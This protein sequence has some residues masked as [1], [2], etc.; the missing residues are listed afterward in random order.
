M[1]DDI[2]LFLKVVEAGSILSVEKKLSIPRSTISRKIR[3][4]EIKVGKD[5]LIRNYQGIVL[6]EEGRV[7]Y[8]RFKDYEKKLSSILSVECNEELS[9]VG[10]L[11]VLLP[12]SFTDALLPYLK[13]FFNNYPGIE[14][15]IL[16]SCK[17]FNMKKEIYDLAVIDYEPSQ[18]DQKFKKLFITKKVLVC[19]TN[20][21]E[22]YP[23]IKSLED[24]AGGFWVGK[25]EVEGIV[26]RK[27][28]IYDENNLTISEIKV[29]HKVIFSDYNKVKSYIMEND[30]IAE[31]PLYLVKSD[32]DKGTLVNIFP[33][34]H[35]GEIKYNLLRNINTDDPRYIIFN[36]LFDQ[37]IGGLM[38]EL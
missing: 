30:G 24:I 12:L 10:R 28:N 29:N 22:K 13:K 25:S 32:L 23:E 14:L 2:L 8:E 16:H 19:S 31:L 35:T 21:L 1:I 27:I 36:N 3:S 9:Y 5:L 34:Y 17:K 4:L 20:N 6:T 18:Q 15:N 11:N 33:T 26:P 38:S 7:F 37:V